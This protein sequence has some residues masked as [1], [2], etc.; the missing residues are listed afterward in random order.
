MKD[1]PGGGE[2]P[3]VDADDA[4]L[5]DLEVGGSIRISRS[6]SS[7]CRRFMCCLTMYLR[8]LLQTKALRRRVNETRVDVLHER[9]IATI[10]RAAPRS[11]MTGFTSRFHCWV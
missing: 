11:G 10:D 8:G 3:P 2:R 9:I 6:S 1:R 5:D 7:R 4:G